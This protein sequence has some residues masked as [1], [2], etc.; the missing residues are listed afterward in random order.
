MIIWGVRKLGKKC[1]FEQLYLVKFKIQVVYDEF[2]GKG[3]QVNR[4]AFFLLV[5]AMAKI[6]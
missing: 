5:A 1:R 6:N 3:K 2:N 4:V